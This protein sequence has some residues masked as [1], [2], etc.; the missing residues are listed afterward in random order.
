MDHADVLER[1]EAAVAAPGGLATLVADPSAEAVALREHIRGCPACGAEWR[2]WSVMSLGLAAA[3]PDTM[4]LRP[5]ARD[6]ILGAVL[7]RPRA[8]PTAAPVSTSMV[9]ATAASPSSDR[10]GNT[11]EPIATQPPTM[12]SIP[13][14]KPSVVPG[15]RTGR[16]ARV[17][18]ATGRTARPEPATGRGAWF[19]W[20]ALAAAAAVLLFV[21]GAAFG[22]PL[23]LGGGD[24]PTRTSD[25]PRVMAVTADVLAGKGYSLAQL[26][27]PN[28]AHGGFVAVSPGSGD[29]VVVSSALTPPPVGVR[30]ICLLDRNGEQSRVGYMRF[31]GSLA[32]WAGPVDDPVDIGL[33]GDQFIVQLDSPGSEPALTGTF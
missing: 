3:A 11:I 10:A 27:T 24:Q 7:S 16:T 2:A 5:A 20:V 13:A 22:R 15:G 8:T 33:T 4:T 19:R 6:A 9:A 23:G 30:Y 17:A 21:A 31:D 14:G 12:G 28:G 25:L 18:A 26:E 1:I 29:L 32:Y